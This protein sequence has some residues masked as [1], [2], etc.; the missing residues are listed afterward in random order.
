[1]M[2][3]NELLEIAKVEIRKLKTDEIFLKPVSSQK[4]IIASMSNGR[5][6]NSIHMKKNYNKI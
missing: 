5:H 3:V 2:N 4:H 6:F 1:M